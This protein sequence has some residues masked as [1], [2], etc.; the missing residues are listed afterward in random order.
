[1]TRISRRLEQIV[2][3][4]LSKNI[5]PIKTLEGILVGDIIIVSKGSLK[6]LKRNQQI[7]YKD[8]YLNAVAIKIANLIAFKQST[9]STDSIYQADQEYGKWFIDSQLLRSQYQKAI[10]IQDYDKADVFWARYLESRDR[11]VSAKN[12]AEALS[13]I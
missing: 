2:N 8:I 5:I 10:S 11:C 9:L 3:H 4:E 6:Q 1:M 7:I 13:R 12:R